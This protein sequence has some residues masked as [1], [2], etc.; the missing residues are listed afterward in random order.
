[1]GKR[2]RRR[3]VQSD[4]LLLEFP[5]CISS[6]LAKNC[7]CSTVLQC[8]YKPAAENCTHLVTVFNKT[9]LFNRHTLD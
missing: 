8:L 4:K 1:M 6:T 7:V 2:L 3:G 5:V 9:K